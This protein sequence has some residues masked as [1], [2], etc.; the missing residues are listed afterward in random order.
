MVRR[1]TALIPLVGFERVQWYE[2]LGGWIDFQNFLSEHR[3]IR[4]V[5]FR[6]RVNKLGL[7][8]Y[9]LIAWKLVSWMFISLVDVRKPFFNPHE[10][11][12]KA[13]LWFYQISWQKVKL[14]WSVS[15]M[16]DWSF[17][18]IMHV[19]WNQLCASVKLISHIRFIVGSVTPPMSTLTYQQGHF[20]NQLN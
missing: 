1:P 20:T 4:Q 16:L 6:V 12:L 13:V 2:S 14:I 18:R 19:Y 3:E 15:F 7:T 10:K 9:L 17:L 8:S 5:L 11:F